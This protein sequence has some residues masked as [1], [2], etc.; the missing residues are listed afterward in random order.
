MCGYETIDLHVSENPLKTVQFGT[1][2]FGKGKKL[3]HDSHTYISALAVLHETT[4]SGNFHMD[5]FLNVFA[6]HPLPVTHIISRT[7]MTVFTVAPG[8]GNEFRGWAK[9]V[10]EE[11]YREENKASEAT[12]ESAPNAASSERES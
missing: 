8:K 11:E 3:R 9:I 1:H 7:D 12:S 10:S 6:D 4:N 5:F 2:R